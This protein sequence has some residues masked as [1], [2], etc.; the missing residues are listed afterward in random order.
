[1]LADRPLPRWRITAFTRVSWQDGNIEITSCT[2]GIALTTGS[3]RI[4]D[5]MHSFARP[6]SITE[7]VAAH[8][9]L[10]RREVIDCIA[11]LIDAG[12]LVSETTT[13][14]AHWIPTAL[15]YHQLSRGGSQMVDVA[16]PGVTAGTNPAPI[17]LG[18]QLPPRSRDFAD[19]LLHRRSTRTW[20]TCQIDRSTF[21]TL[22]WMSAANRSDPCLPVDTSISRP[23]PSGGGVYSLEI[24]P[25]I[26]PSA[27]D[28]LDAGVY[29]YR[30]DDHAL[31]VLATGTA[32]CEP[33][34]TAGAEAIGNSRPPVV[35]VITSRISNQ[36]KAYYEIAYSLVLKEVGGLFQTLY[37]VCEYLGLTGCALGGGSP[38]RLLAGLNETDLLHNPVVGEFVL[39]PG[40]SGSAWQTETG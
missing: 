30:P 14:P 10:P 24:Y 9:Q 38:D 3:A 27:V 22:L 28:S 2:S 15:A 17:P 29:R 5:I 21:S 26:G 33:F 35:F 4:L 32:A 19:V 6:N 34:L 31:E 16:N 20:P 36:S 18:P 8:G 40:G 13:E 23:Y 39:G 37:L 7:V 11:Q 25:V 12:V 1:M